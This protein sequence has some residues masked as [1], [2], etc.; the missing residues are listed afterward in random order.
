MSKDRDFLLDFWSCIVF[1]P[2]Q[3]TKND[4]RC[5]MGRTKKRDFRFVTSLCQFSRGASQLH[6]ALKIINFGWE[7]LELHPKLW[8]VFSRNY[9]P[10]MSVF[11]SQTGKHVTSFCWKTSWILSFSMKITIY[12]F[13]RSSKSSQPKL[14]F[15]SATWSCD[16]PLEN[17]HNEVTYLKSPFLLQPMRH[18]VSF[19]VIWTGQKTIHEQKSSRKSR[20]LETY[21]TKLFWFGFQY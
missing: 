16:A 12:T 8:R 1:W 5:L 21:Y 14:I 7:V 10:K 19:F 9:F 15:L 4:T 6:V 3:I 20:F 2:V 13:G 18:R 11:C 17:W